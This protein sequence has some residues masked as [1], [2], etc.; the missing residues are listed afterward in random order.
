M[1]L[2]N[3][4][5]DV[6]FVKIDQIVQSLFRIFQLIYNAHTT[7]FDILIVCIIQ[8]HNQIKLKSKSSAHLFDVLVLHTAILLSF[9]FVLAKKKSNSGKETFK[10]KGEIMKRYSKCIYRLFFY[11]IR[12]LSSNDIARK[13]IFI[14][15][16]CTFTP[17]QKFTCLQKEVD[18]IIDSLLNKREIFYYMYAF[19]MLFFR[20]QM[21]Y[22]KRSK[23][24]Q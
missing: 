17:V 18:F 12:Q 6:Q 19:L 22:V 4:F 15:T 21:K 20:A 16:K 11:Y 9:S 10:F 14:Y 8:L 23:K 2:V 5:K 3:S 1:C 24:R 13:T 7:T